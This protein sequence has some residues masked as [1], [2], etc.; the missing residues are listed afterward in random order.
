MG[1]TGGVVPAWGG[2]AALGR[3]K[4]GESGGGGEEVATEAPVWASS[5]SEF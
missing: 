2:V 5:S 3:G 4:A 1:H